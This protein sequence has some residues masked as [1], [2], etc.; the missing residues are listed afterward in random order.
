M[1][2]GQRDITPATPRRTAGLF[3]YLGAARCTPGVIDDAARAMYLRGQDHAL[4]L[5]LHETTDWPIVR[6]SHPAAEHDHF[7]VVRPDG[8]LVDI[9][10]ARTPAQWARAHGERSD[11]S[12]AEL[13]SLHHAGPWQAPDVELAMTFVPEVLALAAHGEPTLVTPRTIPL[14]DLD[15]SAPIPVAIAPGEYILWTGTP[16]DAILDALAGPHSWAF[17]RVLEWDADAS[18]RR[19]VSANGTRYVALMPDG[20]VVDAH[21]RTPAAAWPADVRLEVPAEDEEE[22]LSLAPQYAVAS[23]VAEDQGLIPPFE[24]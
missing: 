15:E 22:H 8:Q 14:P 1:A 16:D 13:A 6:G 19:A 3:F 21:G 4:A 23:L 11:V 20:S 5:A 10:G 18:V 7:A 17:A 12:A 2:R 24:G 9:C